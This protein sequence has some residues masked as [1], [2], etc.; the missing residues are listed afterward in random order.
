MKCV[1][2]AAK[3]GGFVADGVRVAEPRRP[4]EAAQRGQQ[5]AVR[6]VEVETAGELALATMEPTTQATDF[7]FD[8]A[9]AGLA[10]VAP[11]PAAIPRGER[12]DAADAREAAREFLH[13]FSPPLALLR[14]R[15]HEGS[16]PVPRSRMPTFIKAMPVIAVQ[17]AAAA[18]SFKSARTTDATTA[19]VTTAAV[20]TRGNAGRF[21]EAL[22]MR[23]QAGPRTHA[24]PGIDVLKE[25]D[26]SLRVPSMDPVTGVV[27]SLSTPRRRL[28]VEGGRVVLRLAGRAL[29]S[30]PRTSRSSKERASSLSP[31]EPLRPLPVTARHDG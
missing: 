14:V 7:E 12:R 9:A 6:A 8:V 11:R 26:A 3:E 18:D 4:V 21:C 27:S 29:S 28:H 25:P 17:R 13:H 5:T 22:S 16:A 15:A 31:A 10:A 19:I 24:Q 23:D 1:K 20:A 2:T 30:S